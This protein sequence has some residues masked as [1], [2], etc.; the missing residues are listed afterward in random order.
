MKVKKQIFTNVGVIVF[1]L[2]LGATALWAIAAPDSFF[3]SADSCS[4]T[5]PFY[6]D[7]DSD[8]YGSP[9]ASTTI[10]ACTL[11]TGYSA[12]N[13]DC[14][15]TRAAINPGATEI[16]DNYDNDCDG[17]NNESLATSTYYYDFDNDAYGVSATTTVWCALPSGYATST[18]DCDDNNAAKNPG[19]TEICDGVDNNCN[20]QIDD[21]AT[22][23]T[24]YYD[25]DN[26]GYGGN[27]TS[28]Q[29]CQKPNG[30]SVTNNDCN[31]FK[32]NTYP[33][34]QEFCDSIDNDCD[35]TVDESCT[36]TYYRDYDGD[37]YG[38]PADS[39]TGTSQPSG[40]VTDKTD[41]NDSNSAIHPGV[42]EICDS[43]D[44]DCDGSVDEGV[45]TT[46]Y[47]D[48]DNDGYGLS[49]SSTTSCTKPDKYVANSQDC[50]D[51]NQNIHPGVNDICDG[52]DN[53]CDG[54]I[55]ENNVCGNH[56][57]ST[58]PAECGCNYKNH[59]GYVSCMAHF[60][61]WL[62][63]LGEIVGKEKGQ[64][65]KEAA[66]NK[67]SGSSCSCGCPQVNITVSSTCP[68]T[69]CSQCANSQQNNNNDDDDEQAEIKSKQKNQEKIRNE[70]NKN[71]KNIEKEQK[72]KNKK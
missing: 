43:V 23:T 31:D 64:M 71:I 27:A 3:V 5:T 21:G 37:G 25:N 8:G 44:N 28:T 10:Y 6:L 13:N 57:T 9:E 32:A 50:N 15:D 62:K 35:G 24:Y 49:A 63:K 22:T 72:N 14:D 12:N 61:N 65:M 45:K 58:P 59:G 51:N 17:A 40:Y 52:I 36:N 46:Y 38:N 68:Q 2:A 56:A 54:T 34:A 60:S 67:N 39:T 4:T 41:C 33:G 42:T 69:Q 48:Y 26:D 66:H 20:G 70:N 16:C 19:A 7:S 47:Y 18:G 30:Y 11:P 1:G 55:D 53:D 29:A